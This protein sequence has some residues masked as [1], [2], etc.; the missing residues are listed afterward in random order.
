MCRVLGV[1]K[2]DQRSIGKVRLAV[3]GGLDGDDRLQSAVRCST[4]LGFIRG[5]A[6]GGH[7]T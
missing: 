6:A 4:G 2:K 1:D 5:V 3:G 7:R